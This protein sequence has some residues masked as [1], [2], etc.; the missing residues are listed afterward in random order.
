[1]EREPAESHEIAVRPRDE[2]AWL[3]E[4]RE[5]LHE[6]VKA[7][8]VPLDYRQ[9]LV[10]LEA[11]RA[12]VVFRSILEI[13]VHVSREFRIRVPFQARLL[14]LAFTKDLVIPDNAPTLGCGCEL[15]APQADAEGSTL[16][17]GIEVQRG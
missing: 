3:S 6:R 2:L 10:F 8:H 12:D 5:A 16:D 9:P 13:P 1:M 11:D 7:F 15:V 17:A 4:E 14:M